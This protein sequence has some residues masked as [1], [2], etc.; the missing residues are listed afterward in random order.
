MPRER[1][2]GDDRAHE[3]KELAEAGHRLPDLMPHRAHRPVHT[4]ARPYF[5]RTCGR[6]QV[7]LYVPRGWYSLCRHAGD[8]ARP[9]R[10][11]IYCSVEC[12]IAGTPRLKGVAD[13][14]GSRGG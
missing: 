4:E 3:A 7:G 1:T 10:L 11:G 12:L 14:I 5:C 8:M 6:E 13:D 2:P 9:L